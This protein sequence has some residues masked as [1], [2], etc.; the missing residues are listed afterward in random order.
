MSIVGL[1]VL[2][3]ILGAVGMQFLRSSKPELV[4]KAEDGI[5]RF[6][7]SIRLSKSND[8]RAKEK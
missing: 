2:G 7:K 6:V 3:I 1:A 5:K 4:E 8:K